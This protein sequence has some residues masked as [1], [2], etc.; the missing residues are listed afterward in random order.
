MPSAVDVTDCYGCEVVARESVGG[1]LALKTRGASGLAFH[2]N[3]I[4]FKANMP[5]G[6]T[7]PTA[8]A[9]RCHV[10]MPPPP[11]PPPPPWCGLRPTY[12]L[13]G[14]K[15]D[16]RG[17]NGRE[18]PLFEAEVHFEVWEAGAEVTLEFQS[19]FRVVSVWFAKQTLYT[20]T[21][22]S[23]EL[24]D[25]PTPPMKLK[26]TGRGS[27]DHVPLIGCISSVVSP[28]HPPPLPPQP[29]P[30]PPRPPGGPPPPPAPLPPPYH[31]EPG[32]PT[33]PHATA[34]SCHTVA[35]TWETPTLG[36]EGLPVAEYAVMYTDSITHIASGSVASTSFEVG[37]LKEKG[38]YTFNL[39]A[40]N[41]RG[42]SQAGHM[43]AA[44]TMPSCGALRPQPPAKPA[45]V[46]IGS[47]SA[48]LSWATVTG[49]APGAPLFW[50]RSYAHDP[51]APRR[52]AR[53]WW[54]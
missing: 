31:A 27:A 10:V 6:R 46:Q 53:R 35:L 8:V 50:S 39:R 26:L 1:V 16:D 29:P 9:I 22:S 44:L 13:T 25:L 14:R 48:R 43:S 40:H 23:F 42:W 32:E 36:A 18:Q 17:R 24:Q 54:R 5:S 45:L 7:A 51:R 52:T 49:H 3:G 37:G 11:S 12:V 21:S 20:P 2:S 33:A 41:A 30:P 34:T 28:P 4:G 47:C 15:D 38:T 19:P